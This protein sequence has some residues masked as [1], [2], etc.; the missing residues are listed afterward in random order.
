MICQ[1]DD[2]AILTKHPHI[3]TSRNLNHRA[4]E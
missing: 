4:A 2:G 3:P 1:Q